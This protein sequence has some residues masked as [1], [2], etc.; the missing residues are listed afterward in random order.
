M[1]TSV[2]PRRHFSAGNVVHL[3]VH[4]SDSGDRRLAVPRHIVES[5]V[6]R[7]DNPTADTRLEHLQR[8]CHRATWSELWRPA[9]CSC[10]PAEPQQKLPTMAG[11]DQS[12]LRLLPS[13]AL[14]ARDPPPPSI[15]SP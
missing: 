7:L 14:T 9:R 15:D 12:R 13:A 3:K 5:P 10:P 4:T 8:S 2:A 6:G 11:V 1:Y